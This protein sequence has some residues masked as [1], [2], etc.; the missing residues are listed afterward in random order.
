MTWYGG[1]DTPPGHGACGTFL[2][3]A[4]E[5]LAAISWEWF[6]SA[7][8]NNDQFCTSNVC[9][10]VTYKNK[11]VTAPIKDRCA[12][13]AKNN[14]DLGKSI[15][16]KLA[17]WNLGRV[18]V[19]WKFV[20]CNGGSPGGG[21]DGGG[22]TGGGRLCQ[23]F[24]SA[25]TIFILFSAVQWGVRLSNHYAEDKVG[26]AEDCKKKCGQDAKCKAMSYDSGT[27]SCYLFQS[28]YSRTDN[29]WTWASWIKWMWKVHFRLV[30][31]F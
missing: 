15:F 27:G 22:T 4:T 29:Q 8:P 10:V 17:S 23:P 9:A 31:L 2:H 14:I 11:S 3:P 28:N 24:Y 1:A 16:A 13:C 5:N 6:T 18:T 7:N 12:G 21:S 19:Q 26:Y 25:N 20:S 30:I